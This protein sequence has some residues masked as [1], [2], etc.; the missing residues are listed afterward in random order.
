M[1]PRLYLNA[2]LP[3]GS[4]VPL[5]PDQA[6]YLRN[7]LRREVGAELLLFNGRDGE[8]TASLTDISKKGAVAFIERQTRPQ[9]VEPDVEIIFALIKR[10]PLEFMLQKAT[11][12]GA[13]RFRPVTTART[14]RERFNKDRAIS[15]VQEA[16]EQCERFTVPALADPISLEDLQQNWEEDRPLVFCDEAGENPEAPWGGPSGRA[17]PML[18]ALKAGAASIDASQSGDKASLL[19]GPEGGFT[20]DERDELRAKPFVC[21]VTL[22]PRILRADTA[23]IAALTLWQA[24]NGDLRRP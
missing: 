2:D 11:E 6:H 7:V 16:A 20:R 8:M 15:I 19:I 23:A 5:K 1:I 3:V 12:L 10:G 4:Q 18:E 21:P 14:N 9:P 17:L 22:G 24:A 13:A